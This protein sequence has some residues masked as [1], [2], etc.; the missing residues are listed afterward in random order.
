MNKRIPRI[1][2][3]ANKLMAAPART[4]TLKTKPS[5][6]PKP[7]AGGVR[8]SG[9]AHASS[10]KPELSSAAI[11]RSLS[12]LFPFVVILFIG[13][14]LIWERVKVGELAAQIAKLE[15]QRLQLT[16]QNGRLRIQLEQLGGYGRISRIAT[17]R[18]GLVAVPQRTILVKED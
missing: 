3:S 2:R 12:L 1:P 7:K 10:P 15:S 13:L 16:E 8:K 9:A 11:K 4:A 6:T 5:T 17:K 14:F 18:L